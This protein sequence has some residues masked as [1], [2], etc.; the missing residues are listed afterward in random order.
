MQLTVIKSG[1][2]EPNWISWVRKKSSGIG[3][4][5]RSTG[6]ERT[7]I[8][9][10]LEST[11]R[12]SRKFTS[13]Y[14]LKV[15][16]PRW[17]VGGL[18][19]CLPTLSNPQTSQRNW[20]NK[21]NKRSSY[22]NDNK[23]EAAAA[24]TLKCCHAQLELSAAQKKKCYPAC[25]SFHNQ[26]TFVNLAELFLFY[27]TNLQSQRRKSCKVLTRVAAATSGKKVATSNGMRNEQWKKERE[28]ENQKKKGDHFHVL[29]PCKLQNESAPKWPKADC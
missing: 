22:T 7:R 15:P 17:A 18:P 11:L 25:A 1:V 29:M 20:A 6:A 28:R 21:F 10:E 24:A 19:C 23:A 3:G 4:I 13:R 12:P 26:N 9:F 14:K 2:E 8:S 27:F 16:T 5:S